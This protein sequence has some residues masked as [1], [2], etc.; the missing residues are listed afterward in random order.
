MTT[1]KIVF[2][3]LVSEVELWCIV[4]WFTLDL[5]QLEFTQLLKPEHFQLL[6]ILGSFQP[7][8]LWTLVHFSSLHTLLWD[9]KI[10]EWTLSLSFHWPLRLCCWFFFQTIFLSNRTNSITLFS[11]SFISSS[12]ITEAHWSP[13]VSFIPF[14]VICCSVIYALFG[15]LY[16]FDFFSEIFYF[17][18]YQENLNCSLKHF[19]DGS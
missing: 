10:R 4:A 16:N 7:L 12:V 3:C 19:Y 17:F 8:F 14:P 5:S 18:L 11:S 2:L 6:P 15:S 9:T 13:S 1:F